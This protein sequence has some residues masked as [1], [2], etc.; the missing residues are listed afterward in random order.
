MAK[1]TQPVKD[2]LNAHLEMLEKLEAINMEIRFVYASI[3]SPN[4]SGMPGGGDKRTSEEERLYQRKEELEERAARK[5]AEI[6]RDWAELEEMVEQL[7]PMETLVINLRY[8]YGEEWDDVCRTI[9]GKRSDFE[10]ELDRYEDKM[11]KAH[12]RALCA[13]ADMMMEREVTK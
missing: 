5:K 10:L 3:K 7:N 13:L 4:F 6:D 9:F 12:G 2:R 11:Y 1:K 8:R